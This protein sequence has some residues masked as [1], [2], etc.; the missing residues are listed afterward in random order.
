MA[1]GLDSRH[2]QRRFEMRELLDANDATVLHVDD[3]GPAAEEVRAPALQRPFVARIGLDAREA[4]AHDDAIRQAERAID[5]DVVVLGHP[6]GEHSEDAFPADE[7]GVLPDR[8]PLD[9]GIEHLRERLEIACDE[10]AIATEKKL[11]ARVTHAAESMGACL[12]LPWARGRH[13]AP[14]DSASRSSCLQAFR[15]SRISNLL[16]TEGTHCLSHSPRSV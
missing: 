10:C 6:L 15:V 2:L 8:H 1:V 12:L 3:A 11:D 4:H 16:Y 14:R 5:G 7:D 13:S 9:V